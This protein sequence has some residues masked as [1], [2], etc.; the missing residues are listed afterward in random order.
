MSWDKRLVEYIY[1][2]Q[3]RNCTDDPIIYLSGPM[4]GIEDMGLS[5]RKKWEELLLEKKWTTLVPNDLESIGNYKRI[6]ERYKND[7]KQIRWW[8]KE[9][10]K[11]DLDAVE[12][13]NAIFVNWNGTRS[14]GTSH[15][16]GHA[17]L[18]GLPVVVIRTSESDVP[19]WLIG[20]SSIVVSSIQEAISYI[21]NT[22]V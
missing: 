15:E 8:M 20:C 21:E 14:V 7:Y 16:V 2:Y 12:M 18:E 4:E 6:L 13:S 5:W 11:L 1:K 10:I 3:T 22:I 9:V 19:N 17:Y